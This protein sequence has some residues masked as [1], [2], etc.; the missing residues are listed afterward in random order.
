MDTVPPAEQAPKRFDTVEVCIYD[1]PPS[2]EAESCMASESIESRVQ[3]LQDRLVNLA[4]K[5]A[6][7]E[8]K[9]SVPEKKTSPILIV[10]LTLCGTAML[11]YL[12]WVGV[13]IVIL[14][15]SIR[16]ISGDVQNLS[17]VMLP[18]ALNAA[19]NDPTNP[20]NIELV[21]KVL[22]SARQKNIP[23][24]QQTIAQVGSKFI[25]AAKTDQRSWGA[26]VELIN[27]RTTLNPASVPPFPQGRC[28]P[29]SPNAIGIVA[30]IESLTLV[31]CVQDL[32]HV[33]WTN[34]DFR[35]TTIVYHGGPTI[36]Q[37]VHFIN[38]KFSLAY[39]PPSETLGESL[40]ADN[41]VNVTLPIPPD[42]ILSR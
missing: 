37:N 7:I 24:R 6:T 28:L 36:L 11:A 42:S 35:D 14:N 32:D 5:V 18:S 12:S 3:S 38:C 4:T 26:A 41:A 33:R 8:G 17:T 30:G 22:E 19:A 15:G 23:I 9:L 16:T 34:V 39:T 2:G 21:G 1:S 29:V 10:F 31:G 20:V 13:E 25:G 40:L 27:Y